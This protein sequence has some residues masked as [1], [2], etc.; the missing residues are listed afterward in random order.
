MSNIHIK[1]CEII[2]HKMKKDVPRNQV[3]NHRLNMLEEE[4]KELYNPKKISY[5]KIKHSISEPS[6][7]FIIVNDTHLLYGN[8]VLADIP[9]RV[10]VTPSCGIV[11][12]NKEL[13][14]IIQ[15]QIVWFNSIFTLLD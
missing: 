9:T 14:K 12:T 4:W 3:F 15:K 10:T 13:G 11:Y 5:L 8:Y 1:K 7:Y 6:H 2:I